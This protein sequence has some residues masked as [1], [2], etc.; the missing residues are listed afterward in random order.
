MGKLGGEELN[1]SSDID[2]IFAYPEAGMTKEASSSTIS[3]ISPGL[4][5]WLSACW[6]PSRRMVCFRVDMRLRPYGD[7]GA[8]VGAYSA[9]EV[10]Y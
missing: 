2:L 9:L 4:V 10:Y 6:M 8:L 1:F 5:R 7:S 3:P